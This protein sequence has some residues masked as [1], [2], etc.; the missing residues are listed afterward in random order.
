MTERATIEPVATTR[1]AVWRPFVVASVGL[2]ITAGF[3]LGGALF[4]ARAAGTGAGAWWPAA[5]QAHGHIQLYGFAGLMVFGVA[6]HFLPRLRGAPLAFAPAAPL[7]LALLGGGLALR[8]IS[9]PVLA[10]LE[11]G[12]LG[13]ALGTVFLLSAV[14]ELAGATL[15][16]T[17]LGGTIAGPALERKGDALRPVLPFFV[18]AF[19]SVWFGLV[20]N[21]AGTFAAA[22][23]GAVLLPSWSDTLTIALA[24]HGFLVPV[25]VAMS[26]RT[27]PLYFQTRLPRVR[28]MLLGLVLLVLGLAL[29]LPGDIAGS[30]TP[31]GVGRLVGAVGLVMFPAALGLLDPRRP[32]PRRASSPLR[33]PLQLHV[34]SAYLWL[35]VAAALAGI[36]G[37]TD[38][39]VIGRLAPPDAEQHAL[40][41]G[42]VLLLILG[43]GGHMLAGFAGRSLRS[44]RLI[45]VT[46]AL[47]NL[48]ALLR[49][50]PVL[51]GRGIVGGG[52]EVLLTLAGLAGALALALFAVNLTGPRR[53]G[54]HANGH[55][56]GRVA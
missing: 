52:S 55:Q 35:V 30:G 54:D 2:G 5:A 43:V 23:V 15:A 29:W 7:V 16:L 24:F 56:R 1:D 50:A 37:L 45:W 14:L 39:G 36:A 34:L 25:A 38:L 53:R 20:G 26:A 46:L 21:L 6:F 18:A 27:F 42:F 17:M 47:A 28:L 40:G 10:A 41:A 32:L 13:W 8:G 4:A 49:V 33:D 51:W 44:R 11:P 3:L 19:A 22:R 9:Q 12:A 31:S 48:A